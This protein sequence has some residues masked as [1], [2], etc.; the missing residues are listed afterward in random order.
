MLKISDVI[1]RAKSSQN[2]YS[3]HMTRR[4][5]WIAALDTLLQDLLEQ[6]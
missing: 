3:T 6:I 2:K 1:G 5:A 4:P